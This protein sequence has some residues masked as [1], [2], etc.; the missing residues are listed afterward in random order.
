MKLIIEIT[1]DN[2]AFRDDASS[3]AARILY[4]RTAL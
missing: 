1:M 3:E 2:A 4:C